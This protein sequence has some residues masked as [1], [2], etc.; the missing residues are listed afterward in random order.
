M[1]I[2]MATT[3]N[4]RLLQKDGVLIADIHYTSVQMYI[5]VHTCTVIAATSTVAQC[6]VNIPG[7]RTSLFYPQTH[8]KD[9]WQ[10]RSATQRGLGAAAADGM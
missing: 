2:C 7:L 3:I 1:Q 4:T 5:H 8:F 10:Q 6:C 9:V